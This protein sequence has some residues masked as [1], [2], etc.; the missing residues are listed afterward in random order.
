[1]VGFSSGLFSK[2]QSI[3]EEYTTEHNH[4]QEILGLV[5]EFSVHKIEIV[6]YLTINTAGVKK[7][8]KR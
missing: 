6:F 8:I 7:I 3:T 4:W 5:R 1:M 2:W